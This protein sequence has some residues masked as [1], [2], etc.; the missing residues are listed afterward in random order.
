MNMHI[1]IHI[2][3]VLYD[4]QLAAGEEKLEKERFLMEEERVQRDAFF[5]DKNK[6]IFGKE[7]RFEQ[8]SVAL[9]AYR[10]TVAAE[11][12]TVTYMCMNMARLSHAS[13][14]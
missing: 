4:R 14:L 5:S 10:S 8:E 12:C 13:I 2:L 1:L 11:V 7:L 9:S 3:Y 6:V